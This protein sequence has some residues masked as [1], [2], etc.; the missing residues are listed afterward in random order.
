MPK[1]P[2]ILAHQE[3][4]AY[5][6]PTGLV[7]SIP[8][9]VDASA[10]LN[11]NYGPDHQR[12]LSALPQN[13]DHEVVP[14]IP[15]FVQFARDVLNWDATLLN[16]SPDADPIPV[17]L[18]VNL[19]SYNETLRPKYALKNLEGERKWLLLVDVFPAGTDLDQ[20]FAPHDRA[21]QASPQARFEKLLRQTGVGIG[22]LVNGHEIRLVYAPE[23]EL[24]G[25]VTF[26]LGEMVRVA[27][28]PIFAAL[29]M[30]LNSERLYSVAEKERLP[31][32]LANSRKYQNVVSTQLAEQVLEAL[33]EM[34]RG[35]QAANDQTKGELLRDILAR[36]PDRVYHGLLTTLLRLVFV[37]YAED[38]ALL[39]T[40]PVYSNY[41]SVR[42]L[43][44]RLRADAG[45]YNDTMDQR[46]GAWAQLLALFRLVYSGGSHGGMR[47][48]AREGYLFD[49]D[50]YLFLE[51]RHDKKDKPVIPRVSDGV[52]YRVLSNLVLLDGE[53]L[54]YRWLAVEQIGSVYQA[55]MGFS[56]QVA[57]GRSIAIRP[58][59]KHGAPATINLEALL[60]TAADKRLKRFTDETD[61]KLTGPSADALKSAETI[62]DLLAA[63]ERKIAK[64]VTP[65]PV[66]KDAMVFQP[67]D[68][69]R[70]SG[71]HYTPSSLT[72]PIVEAALEP[73]LKQ[74]GPNPTP[75]QILSLKV[76]DLAMG[77]AAF[78]VEACRQLGDALT[79]AWQLH[80]EVQV[81]PPDEDEA[82]YAQRLIAQR[83]L[84]GLDKNQMAADLAKLSLWLATLAKDH[85]FTF[86]DHSLRH[87]D[88]LVGLT[89]KQIASFH[90]TPAPQQSFLEEKLRNLVEFVSRQR[91]EILNALDNTPYSQ[92][93]QELAVADGK[94][95]LLR[96]IGDAAIAAFFG[97]E[98][99]KRRED[100]RNRLLSL[101]E[102]DLKKQG[103][104]SVDGV[105]D[106]AIRTL[107][108][109]PKGIV[110][111]HWEL[112][113]PEVFGTGVERN[114][115]RGFD[116][117][118][119]N[120]PFAGKNTISQ[121][122]A[123]GYLD[124]LKL[125]HE[126]S[127]GNSDLVAH[128]FRR[129]FNLLRPNGDLGL[130]ATKTVG[131][132][133]TRSTGLR[134]I[135]THGGVIYRAR[136]RL[137]W[138]GQAAVTVS[139]V[140]ICKGPVPP[141]YFLDLN[142]V[143]RITAYLFHAGIHDDPIRL[144]ANEQM[145]GEGCIVLGMGFTFDS[146]DTDGTT[147]SIQVMRELLE[148]TPRNKECI[149][150]Y[151][152]GEELNSSPKHSHHRY[153]INFRDWPLRR[154]NVG[155][156]ENATDE[157]R[158]EWLH[159][160]IVPTDYTEPVASD[161][162]D[163]LNILEDKVKPIRLKDNREN[164]R[165]LWWQYA[166]RR[167]T[168]VRKLQQLDRVLAISRV[169]HVFAFTFLSAKMVHGESL[170]LTLSDKYSLFCVLQSR[171]HEIWARLLASSLEDRLR[172]TPTDCF[173]TFPLPVGMEQESV[174]AKIGEAY[175]QCRSNLMQNQEIG[176]TSV[177]NW[178]HDPECDYSEIA[179]LRALHADMDSAVLMAYG[180]TGVQPKCEFIAEDDA[181]DEDDGREKRKR[182]RYRWPDGIRD[183][184]LA[185]LLELNRRRAL[186]EDP[187]SEY[188]ASVPQT[189]PKTTG[190][191]KKK[192]KSD[193]P[194]QIAIELGEA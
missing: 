9:L 134:W 194:D 179:T 185:L 31:A 191:R 53:R 76:C 178:F 129:S 58:A 151:I 71:S 162:P 135:C 167:P 131:Q 96:M 184:V 98:K 89:R 150:P 46:Y 83:C 27:G 14:E 19:E 18:E 164:Y 81:I 181:E 44:E 161:F 62:E 186:E 117:I 6:Q 163:L 132:G 189:E 55:I 127:H 192:G 173:E 101:V 84:Y 47:I 110:P 7:V 148:R 21:W 182:Y 68:E 67:S 34:L 156:W 160:G 4:L 155:S 37:L 74:L 2:A 69:R 102:A 137:K 23:K 77:S 24:S 12:F 41:Y 17:E 75:A 42:G 144:K 120:P 97:E 56:L 35:F 40:D 39:S 5:V 183:E 82:L 177:Y 157:A 188:S 28:R 86:L 59:K 79:R 70:R 48:P 51:G 124:W 142:P 139:V 93:E 73:V 25:Y 8:A 146:S 63:L 140:H 80:R 22:L 92:L 115:G 175:H 103:F 30:L 49:P 154:G 99:P 43:Y 152:G 187:V 13:A 87:G 90:W 165:R 170:V 116:V 60:G 10:F 112:E 106:T 104:I 11:R 119:G 26:K 147:T 158:K 109:G 29:L 159:D 168:L 122:N 176:L 126:E 1:D 180:W 20:P 114:V 91:Q 130:I 113:F 111:F 15:D 85:P 52:L 72:G 125:I 145:S 128:F 153:I 65:V 94:L 166:E 38:R 105:V 108:K 141:P 88:A 121:S 33:Y 32:I 136:R 61:Q 95:G 190:K 16:G 78:L 50:R 64:T 36:D 3:W 45:R 66:P 172:Y 149:F 107:R 171:V 133:D 118:I 57:T 174:L 143:D 138:P 123:Q 193:S 54:S 169:T 100:S